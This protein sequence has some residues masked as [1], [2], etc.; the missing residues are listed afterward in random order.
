MEIELK[1]G[2]RLDDLQRNGYRLIQ[3]PGY[4]RFGMDAVLLA[5]FARIKPGERVLDLGT[6]TGIIPI[7]LEGRYQKGSY[8]GL[9]L[10]PEIADMARRSVLLNKLEQKIRIVTGD[11]REASDLFGKGVFQVVTCNPPYMTARHGLQNPN[12]AKAIARHEVFCTLKDVALQSAGLL[13]PGG[14]LYLVHRPFRLA[15]IMATLQEY[16]LEPKRMRLIHPYI[17]RE[18]NMVLLEASKGGKP[19]IAVE[20]PLIIYREPG[21]YSDELCR[22]YGY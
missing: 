10:Q 12:R 4:F 1:P 9:E 13:G 3:N 19:G 17:D 22:N 14:R 7:L 21:T 6:G 2:E 11:I 8:T 15:E 16:G 5:G 20:P 18:P